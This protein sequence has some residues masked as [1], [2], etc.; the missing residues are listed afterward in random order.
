[1]GARIEEATSVDDELVEAFERLAPQLSRSNPPP[2]RAELEEIVGSPATVLLIARDDAGR[3]VAPPGAFRDLFSF[4]RAV[5]VEDITAE[6]T[7]V[8]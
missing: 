1:M 8:S 7:Q 5:I 3:I 2:S 6:D 4:P